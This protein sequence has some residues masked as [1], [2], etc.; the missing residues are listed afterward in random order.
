ME[1]NHKYRFTMLNDREKKDIERTL[2]ERKREFNDEV[3]KM[4]K[5]FG[6]NVVRK[7]KETK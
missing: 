5:G 3:Y 2:Y 7:D 6:L 4:L 1:N